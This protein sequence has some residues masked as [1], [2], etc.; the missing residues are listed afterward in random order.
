M[1]RTDLPPADPAAGISEAIR[2]FR[3]KLGLYAVLSAL[4]G[5]VTGGA[6]S[7]AV[8]T[9]SMKIRQA[10][11]GRIPLTFAAAV[12]FLVF[13]AVLLLRWP[14]RKETARKVDALGLK[15]RTATML[16]FRN[17]SSGMAALQRQDAL[18]SLG[19]VEMKR[20][21]ERI[22]WKPLLCCL[23]ALL[24]AAAS[25][26]V[27][28]SWFA[29]KEDPFRDRLEEVL[30]MLR[31]EEER[32]RLQGE[33]VLAGETGDLIGRLEDADSVLGA[34]G[35]INRS[36]DAAKD[37]ARNEEADRGAMRE[38]L[39]VLEE[40]KRILLDKE[41]EEEDAEG[42]QQGEF[43]EG[44][45]GESEIFMPGGEGEDMEGMPGEGEDGG[46]SDEDRGF[47]HGTEAGGQDGVSRMT[48]PVYD[49]ISGAV[50]YGDVFS[51]YYSDYL[52]DAENGEVPFELQMPAE[53]YFKELDQ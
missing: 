40:A 50:P 37:A 20:V 6:L 46:D 16:A 8:V 2:P 48:E 44:M 43:G 23:I 19:T 42:E 28:A 39:G 31:E 29:P 52:K 53:S 1:N 22:G 9:L 11:P 18:T 14:T 27:P 34:V 24:L 41:E 25:V 21:R 7:Y 51:S 4:I 36:E 49:P 45:M 12:G 10:E 32:L 15:E 38:M 33:D 30:R 5:F 35:E 3:L 13:L 26:L 17:D 47:G